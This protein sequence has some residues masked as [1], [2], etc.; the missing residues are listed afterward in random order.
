MA[1]ISRKGKQSSKSDRSTQLSDTSIP[2]TAI[3]TP[4]IVSQ[5]LSESEATAAAR[6]EVL[7]SLARN[8]KD[9]LPFIVQAKDIHDGQ[10]FP[11]PDSVLK[12]IAAAEEARSFYIKNYDADTDPVLAEKNLEAATAC[13]AI[14]GENPTES[15]QNRIKLSLEEQEDL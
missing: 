13:C 12:I 8:A 1:R 14:I 15:L 2:E 7:L 5:C 6:I 11:S 3:L 9:P 4:E 10:D